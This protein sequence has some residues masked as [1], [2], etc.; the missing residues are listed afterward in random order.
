MGLLS[1]VSLVLLLSGL[2]L[3]LTVFSLRTE[4]SLTVE[5]QIAYLL[6]FLGLPPFA[7]S[8]LIRCVGNCPTVSERLM[9]RLGA[10]VFFLLA[11]LLQLRA[12]GKKL[13][14][15]PTH[16]KDEPYE[17]GGQTYP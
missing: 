10:N 1:I 4:G 3:V 9:S 2:G 12:N 13:D 5:D 17:G 11:F 6:V 7:M 15:G 8:N 16:P 14:G